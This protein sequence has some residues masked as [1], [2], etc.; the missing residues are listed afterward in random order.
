MQNSFHSILKWYQLVSWITLR[1]QKQPQN[2]SIFPT[3][4]NLF[5]QRKNI[6]LISF[7][8]IQSFDCKHII[9]KIIIYFSNLIQCLFKLFPSFFNIF[10]LIASCRFKAKLVI[11]VRTSAASIKFIRFANQHLPIL[12]LCANLFWRTNVAFGNVY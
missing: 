5:I 1:F 12:T 9:S 2:L 8:V 10:S 11:I 4:F 6:S 3:K 7:F